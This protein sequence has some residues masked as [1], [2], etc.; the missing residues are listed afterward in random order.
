MVRAFHWTIQS[1]VARNGQTEYFNRTSR[2]ERNFTFLSFEYA[3][4]SKSADFPG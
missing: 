3:L 4:S 2:N 1:K